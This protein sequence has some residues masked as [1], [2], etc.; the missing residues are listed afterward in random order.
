MA[1]IELVGHAREGSALPETHAWAEQVA[2]LADYGREVQ[3]G[4]PLVQ[5]V[6]AVQVVRAVQAVQN[7]REG[8]A[9]Q[10]G[11]AGELEQHVQGEVEAEPPRAA[12]RVLAQ[13]EGDPARPEAVQMVLIPLLAAGL[14]ASH[15]TFSTTACLPQTTLQAEPRD[16]HLR[17]HY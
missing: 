14:Q 6:R 12:Q 17:A 7:A 8:Q 16:R 13:S 9:V 10:A 1:Q 4:A 15:P 2:L 3:P 5:S 11:Q